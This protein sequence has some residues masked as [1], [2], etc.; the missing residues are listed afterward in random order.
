MTIQ[1]IRDTQKFIDNILICATNEVELI[2]KMRTVLT[3]C[4]NHNLI[5]KKSKVE[6]GPSID[7][8]GFSVSEK[9]LLPDKAKVE[10][11]SKFPK[12]NNLTE[13]RGFLGLANQLGDS[14][15]ILPF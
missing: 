13:L 3:N 15:T 1:G 7:F 6:V 9:G 2:N 11:I 10:A 12:P 14:L 4:R 5:I 8:A